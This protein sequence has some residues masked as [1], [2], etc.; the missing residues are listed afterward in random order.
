VCAPA[1]RGLPGNATRASSRLAVC[2][3]V[4]VALAGCASV[5]PTGPGT[6]QGSS[7]PILWEVSDIGRVISSDNQRIRWSYLITLRNPTDRPIQLER[8]ERAVVG[9]Y[10]D[11]VGGTPTSLP[12]RRTLGARSD[13]HISTSDN[14]GWVAPSNT[15]FG[16][17]A[18]LRGITA[19]RRFSGG[20]D[21]G[22]PI[23]ISVQVRLDRAIG[24]L[25]R[26]ATRPATLPT[27]T[28]LESERDLASLAG[29]W[30]G[31]YRMEGS[32]LDVP[33][34]LTIAADGSCQAAENDPVTNRFHRTVRVKDGGLDYSGDRERGT[35][36]LH[37]GRGR[38]MLAGTIAQTDGPS[39]AFYLEAQ[40]ASAA[41]RGRVPRSAPAG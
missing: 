23:H 33:F 24:R 7:G 35:L 21:R 26:P 16:G 9:D 34:E 11:S 40:R 15:A 19:F 28:V 37:E 2:I 38:R 5:G 6:W 39:Y 31:S 8:V 29:L 10:G 1:P 25:A 20:D 3:A 36:T 32:L 12:F 41:M 18:M 30:R 22:T 13:L 17:A 27:A 14:W 4:L